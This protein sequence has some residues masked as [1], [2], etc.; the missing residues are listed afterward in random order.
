MT[1]HLLVIILLSGALTACKDIDG[2][3]LPGCA[4]YAGDRIELHAGD[5]VWAKFT[6]EVRVN[7]AGEQIDPFPGYPRAGTYRL[8]DNVVTMVMGNGGTNVMFYL[9]ADD[10]R[11][12]LLTETQ[13]K[14][15]ESSGQYEECALTRTMDN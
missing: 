12:L 11:L 15:W 4:A 10:G 6:D 14:N 9:H 5:V 7:A 13:E 2:V 8:D 3:Y 1:R